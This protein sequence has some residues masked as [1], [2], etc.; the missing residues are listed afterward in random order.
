MCTCGVQKGRTVT[1]LHHLQTLILSSATWPAS[2]LAAWRNQWDPPLN[3]FIHIW[4]CSTMSQTH[5]KPS[6]KTK[7][8]YF[9]RKYRHNTN[10]STRHKERWGTASVRHAKCTTSYL[11]F[12]PLR[13]SAVQ[14]L[15][16]I[17]FLFKSWS[18][19]CTCL[20]YKPSRDGSD[21]PRVFDHGSVS[22]PL[23]WV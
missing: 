13:G 21:F 12:G 4:I 23:L 3:S 16:L 10:V 5:W 9:K 19:F 8:D 2:L 11:C 1:D 14:R 20:S 17:I 18:F 15:E 22:C 7:Q 6:S